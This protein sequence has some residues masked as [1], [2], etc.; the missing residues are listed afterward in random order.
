MFGDPLSGLK[1]K[2]ASFFLSDI[3]FVGLANLALYYRARILVISP[4]FESQ[5]CPNSVFKNSIEYKESGQK[6]YY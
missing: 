3:P 6:N 2:S 5:P 1:C 4:K